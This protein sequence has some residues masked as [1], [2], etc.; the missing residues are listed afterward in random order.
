MIDAD[1]KWPLGAI[2]GAVTSVLGEGWDAEHPLSLDTSLIYDLGLESLE[3]VMI[4]NELHRLAPELDLVQRLGGVE[5]K[6]LSVGDLVVLLGRR[7]ASVA[8]ES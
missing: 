1:A 2:H 7:T 3:L 5:V 8:G 4:I 6:D